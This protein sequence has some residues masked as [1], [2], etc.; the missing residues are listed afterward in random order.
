MPAVGIFTSRMVAEKDVDLDR[1]VFEFYATLCNKRRPIQLH[2]G[3]EFCRNKF[4]EL[5]KTYTLH[6]KELSIARQLVADDGNSASGRVINKCIILFGK[7][8]CSKSLKF[9]I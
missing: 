3:E 7:S 2:K 5:Y 1:K 4:A 9:R 8:R 6:S